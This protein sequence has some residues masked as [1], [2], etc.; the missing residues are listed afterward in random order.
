M[1]LVS[2]HSR[3]GFHLVNLA[4]LLINSVMIDNHLKRDIDYDAKSK[5]FFGRASE[6]DSTHSGLEPNAEDLA[7]EQDGGTD[8]AGATPIS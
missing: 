7:E 8:K 6:G 1:L 2:E 4:T 3:I 5:A